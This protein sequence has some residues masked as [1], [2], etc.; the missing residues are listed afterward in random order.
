[1]EHLEDTIIQ[2]E[3]LATH[4]HIGMGEWVGLRVT[5]RGGGESPCADIVHWDGAPRI[6]DCP[7]EHDLGAEGRELPGARVR[8]L[9]AEDHRRQALLGP[10]GCAAAVCFVGI[11][12]RRQVY[13]ADAGDGCFDIFLCSFPV[14]LVVPSALYYLMILSVPSSLVPSSYGI[15]DPGVPQFV[16]ELN[17]SLSPPTL[18][19][20]C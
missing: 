19:L 6:V 10:V 9:E 5:P 17:Q 8:R 20:R 13:L 14:A 15:E 3:K 4:L 1:L 11:E 18:L 7:H 2:D 12:A 16:S